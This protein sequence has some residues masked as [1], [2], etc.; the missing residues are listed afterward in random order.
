MLIKECD[1]CGKPIRL[2]KG[3]VLITLR[4]YSVTRCGNY[5]G[6]GLESINEICSFNCLSE[7]AKKQQ[8]MFDSLMPLVIEANKEEK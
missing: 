3:D 5:T 2:K 4:G 7:Y 8:K 1:I 6:Y